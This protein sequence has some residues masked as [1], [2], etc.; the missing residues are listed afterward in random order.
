MRRDLTNQRFNKLVVIGP[1]KKEAGKYFWG[2]R[3]DCGNEVFIAQGNLV[4]GNSKSCGCARR[5]NL[6]HGKSETPEWYLWTEA[7]RRAKEKGLIFTLALTDIVIPDVCP[8]L[9][10]NLFKVGEVLT[11]NSP[12]LDRLI[13]SLGYTKENV[14]VVSHKAN[15][16]KSYGTAE[17]HEAVARYIRANK[18]SS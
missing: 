17:D 2:C 9:G 14:I 5:G 13:P 4:S 8:V 7:K 6:V 10:I 16:L 12:T 1:F 18:Q 11:A 15:T 3:C